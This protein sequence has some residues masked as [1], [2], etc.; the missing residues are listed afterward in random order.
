M[1]IVLLITL[2]ESALLALLMIL[3]RYRRTRMPALV[4]V[5]PIISA[6]RRSNAE[7]D[8]HDALRDLRWTFINSWKVEPQSD[9]RI[10]A[11][12]D[13]ASSATTSASGNRSVARRRH[14]TMY[15]RWSQER[16]D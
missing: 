5:G 9:D 1:K 13:V 2:V 4:P 14:Q 7:P 15:K 10:P 16:H 11:F 8:R 6:A 12:G 3:W